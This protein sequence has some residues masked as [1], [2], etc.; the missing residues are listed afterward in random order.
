MD[1]RELYA[2]LA[3]VLPPLLG[4]GLVE[5]YVARDAS[6]AIVVTGLIAL[7]VVSVLI[8]ALHDVLNVRKRHRSRHRR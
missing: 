8:A 4:L 2:V 5:L 1:N 3:G 7:A 6:I